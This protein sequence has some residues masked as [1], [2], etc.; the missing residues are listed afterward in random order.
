MLDGL[1]PCFGFWH[2]STVSIWNVQIRPGESKNLKELA[3]LRKGSHIAE[4]AE[5]ARQQGWNAYLKKSGHWKFVPPTGRIL[6]TG[7]TPS[8]NRSLKNFERDLR[9]QGFV[10]KA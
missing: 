5:Q 1:R 4:L 10:A 3:A 2:D 6:F 7:S 8:D 9:H